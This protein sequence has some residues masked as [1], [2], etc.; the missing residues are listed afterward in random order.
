MKDRFMLAVSSADRDFR[1]Y[2]YGETL[3]E[4]FNTLSLA[5]FIP[6]PDAGRMVNFI[7]FCKYCVGASPGSHAIYGAM[8]AEYPD[9]QITTLY[10]FLLHMFDA[11]D[12]IPVY[13]L[14]KTTVFGFRFEGGTKIAEY[15]PDNDIQELTLV[16]N[17]TYCRSEDYTGA[18][19]DW[20]RASIAYSTLNVSSYIKEECGVGIVSFATNGLS[21][22]IGCFI[23]SSEFLSLTGSRQEFWFGRL[24]NMNEENLG[25][26]ILNPPEGFAP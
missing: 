23:V 18:L 8:K 16:M 12:E 15:R 7:H 1:V 2:S 20:H 9:G 14:M 24:P 21:A 4:A 10:I 22:T 11:P 19:D 26:L 17:P 3:D 13:R 25:L 5:D 6:L